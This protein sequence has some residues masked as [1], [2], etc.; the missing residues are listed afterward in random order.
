LK[1]GGVLKAGHCQG[2]IPDLGKEGAPSALHIKIHG[3]FQRFVAEFYLLII[4]QR[5]QIDEDIHIRLHLRL[6]NPGSKYLRRRLTLIE[7]TQTGNHFVL[8]FVFL[9]GDI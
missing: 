8:G 7:K 6:P 3:Q 1:S 5:Y 9:L 4:T 2:R